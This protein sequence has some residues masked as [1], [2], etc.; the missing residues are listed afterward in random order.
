MKWWE[1]AWLLLKDILAT[2]T[3]LALII[4][5]VF[6]RTPSDVLLVAGLALTTP[7]LASHTVKLLSAPTVPERSDEQSTA[8]GTRPQSSPSSPSGG[9]SPSSSDPGGGGDGP[10]A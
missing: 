9:S 4:T 1:T 8:H 5:Q 2:G 10:G 7:S 3:G 6:A